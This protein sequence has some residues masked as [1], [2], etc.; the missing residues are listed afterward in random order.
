MFQWMTSKVYSLYKKMSYVYYAFQVHSSIMKASEYTKNRNVN[1]Y[2]E[3]P[4]WSLDNLCAFT[5][6]AF[7]IH[8]R[9]CKR[10]LAPT[11]SHF[12]T[13]FVP[14]LQ[15]KKSLSNFVWGAVTIFVRD[16]LCDIGIK[17]LPFWDKIVRLYR[18]F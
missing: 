1:N 12:I 13:L 15:S 2:L 8:V 11:R 18:V 14:Y 6:A 17:D 3:K 9:T 16:F 10:R 7:D 4:H 5:R